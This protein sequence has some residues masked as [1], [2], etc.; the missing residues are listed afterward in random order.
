MEGKIAFDAFLSLR[1]DAGEFQ[2]AT[3]NVTSNQHSVDGAVVLSKSA[4]SRHFIMILINF[5]YFQFAYFISSR[6]SFEALHAA[7]L[8]CGPLP[9]LALNSSREIINWPQSTRLT[10]STGKIREKKRVFFHVAIFISISDSSDQQ[11]KVISRLLPSPRLNF[12]SFLH[13]HG[14]LRHRQLMKM[15]TFREFL[16]PLLLACCSYV[17]CMDSP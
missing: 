6:D 9:R 1:I 13:L 5:Y 14:T 3:W 15:R 16:I 8:H 2:L 12:L 7:D 11:Q 4:L 10:I 17:W